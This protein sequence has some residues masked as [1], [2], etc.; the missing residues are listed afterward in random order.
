LPRDPSD[1]DDVD[2]LDVDVHDIEDDDWDEEPPDEELSEFWLKL[3]MRIV[4]RVAVHLGEG[5]PLYKFQG[6]D[7]L[8]SVEGG[9]GLVII[10]RDPNL[11][12]KVAIKVLKNTGSAAEAALLAEAQT[13]ATLSHQNVVTVHH[14]GKCDSESL[15]AGSLY[16]VMEYVEGTDGGQWLRTHPNWQQIRD[17]FVDAAMGLAAAHDAGIQHR[18]FK[19]ANMLVGKDGRTRVA[20][21]GVADKLREFANDDEPIV[22]PGTPDYMAPERLRGE[23]GDARS[24]QFSF[25]VSLWRALH[26]L[27]LYG[28]ENAFRF[29]ESGPSLRSGAAGIPRGVIG[30]PPWLTRVVLKTLAHNPDDRYPNMHEVVRALKGEPPDDEDEADEPNDDDDSV[31]PDVRVLH[32]PTSGPSHADDRIRLAMV[33]SGAVAMLAVVAVTFVATLV[34]LRPPATLHSPAESSKPAE[35]SPDAPEESTTD[36]HHEVTV[37]QVIK[38]VEAGRFNDAKARWRSEYHRRQKLGEP[39]HEETARI[40]EAC[41]ELAQKRKD[42]ERGEEARVAAEQAKSFGIL[43]ASDFVLQSDG[44]VAGSQGVGDPVDSGSDLVERA[45]QFIREL[46]STANSTKSD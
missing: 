40:G 46:D 30:V 27:A 9:M 14:V 29:L 42:E 6:Y 37:D 21:F 16:M 4:E 17:V 35:P 24:D 38:L 33:I 15:C 26:G 18:D 39:V 22:G 45:N 3:R 25:G 11:E 12:R 8:S 41:L 32:A 23:R 44:P 2:D 5:G 7:C 34:V 19:P 43:A 31:E 1:D 36:P 10:A 20:D 13:L 28:G